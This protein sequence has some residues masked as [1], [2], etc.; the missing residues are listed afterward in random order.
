MKSFITSYKY[1]LAALAVVLLISIS[2][3]VFGETTD[4]QD[5]AVAKAE[6]CKLKAYTDPQ[7]MAATMADPAKYRTKDEV[8]L[9]KKRDPLVLA[10]TRIIN[11]H[12]SVASQIDDIKKS[13]EDEVADAVQFANDAPDPDPADVGKYTYYQGY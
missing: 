1:T 13:V 4:K 12:P 5:N 2:T 9:W 11:E 10:E 8:E 3:V 7:V 6:E